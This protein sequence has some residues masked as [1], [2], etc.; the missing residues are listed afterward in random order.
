MFVHGLPPS[1]EKLLFSVSLSPPSK[2]ICTHDHVCTIK[3]NLSKARTKKKRLNMILNFIINNQLRLESEGQNPSLVLHL[4]AA[5][6]AAASCWMLLL[7]LLPLLQ[8]PNGHLEMPLCFCCLLLL[9]FLPSK[10]LS[11]PLELNALP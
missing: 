4:T 10:T 6:A 5:D 1:P 7:L 8:L 11:N 2:I 3:R 9:A